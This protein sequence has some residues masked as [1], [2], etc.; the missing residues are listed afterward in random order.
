MPNYPAII[1]Q[2]PLTVMVHDGKVEEAKLGVN[3]NP[4]STPWQGASDSLA[5]DSYPSALAGLIYCSGTLT[6]DGKGSGYTLSHQGIL[7]TAG[8]C[9]VDRTA[10]TSI[11]YEDVYF[12]NPPPGFGSFNAP[13]IEFGSW[14][15][16][17]SY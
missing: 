3:F 12:K 1:V 4:T 17:P 6:L 13:Q 8:G 11:Q 14:R 10:K 16:T 15:Q 2:G 5:D 9:V 7:M